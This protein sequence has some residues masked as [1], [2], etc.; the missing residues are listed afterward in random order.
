M[1]LNKRQLELVLLL[2]K[3]NKFLTKEFISQKLNVSIRTVSNDISRIRDELLQNGDFEFISKAGVGVRLKKRGLIS[4]MPSEDSSVFARRFDM[5][6]MLL[7]QEQT[8]TYEVLSELFLVSKSSIKN[9]LLFLKQ[10][11]FKKNGAELIGSFQGT[12]IVGSE[13]QLQNTFLTFNKFIC[14]IHDQNLDINF[15][16]KLKTLSKYYGREIVETCWEILYEHVKSYT[17]E[18]ADIYMAEALN[19]FII[20][21]YRASKGYHPQGEVDVSFDACNTLLVSVTER[22]GIEFS[23]T[24]MR[25]F[26]TYL[27]NNKLGAAHEQYEGGDIPNLVATFIDK[28]E[29]CLGVELKEDGGLKEALSKHF[30][31]LLSRLQIREVIENPFLEQIKVEYPITFSAVW[32]VVTELERAMCLAFNDNEVGFLAIYIQSALERNHIANKILVVCP[33]GLATSQL[34]VNKLNQLLPSLDTMEV[35]AISQLKYKDL[36]QYDFVISTVPFASDDVEVQVVSDVLN[37]E[38]ISN[39]YTLFNRKAV[40]SKQMKSFTVKH[41]MALY[42]S[43]PNSIQIMDKQYLNKNQALEEISRNLIHNGF[44]SDEFVQD[45]LERE[46]DPDISTDLPTGVSIPHGNPAFVNKTGIFFIRN[47]KPIFWGKHAVKMIIVLCIAQKD[48]HK[49]NGILSDLYSIV[50]SKKAI[51]MIYQFKNIDDFSSLSEH[52]G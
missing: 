9:D 27:S 17:I 2:E 10:T 20:L 22:M 8:V 26:E 47:H 5:M 44:V 32:L 52:I 41:F 29:Q 13:T 25:R 38:D 34:L 11:F 19:V 51:E 6:D 1:M 49:I 16:E 45:I 35:S 30:P 36:T 14:R 43:T 21:V 3:A 15:E 18:I 28:M 37:A 7:F 46:N 12:K 40:A 33:T 24:D 31:A 48:H 23:S 4:V 50:E 42:S 39:L